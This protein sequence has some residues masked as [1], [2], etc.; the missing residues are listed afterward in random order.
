MFFLLIQKNY[1]IHFLQAH[2]S[3]CFNFGI[4]VS[5]LGCTFE[6]T[7]VFI[8][9][10]SCPSASLRDSRLVSLMCLHAHSL[11]SC[12]VLYNPVDCQA[13]LSMGFSRQEYWSGL[14][15]S[16]SEDLPNSGIKPASSQAPALQVDSLP[17][18]HW[19]SP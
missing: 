16:S 17:L 4:V 19:G 6:I 12:P 11:Q 1:L 5:N 14:A 3:V 9:L 13:P 15:R 18:S 8:F 7:W 10:N 2:G